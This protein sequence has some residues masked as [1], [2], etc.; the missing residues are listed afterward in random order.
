MI[1]LSTT[2]FVKS[3]ATSSLERENK[4]MADLKIEDFAVTPKITKKADD[5][6]QKHMSLDGDLHTF[7]KAQAIKK[8]MSFRDYGN[9]LLR[10]QIKLVAQAEKISHNLKS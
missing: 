8:N 5:G 6:K 1:A 4:K 10:R 2:L 7:L 9:L 3:I